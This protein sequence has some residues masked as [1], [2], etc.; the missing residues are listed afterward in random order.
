MAHTPSAR[1]RFTTRAVALACSQILAPAADAQWTCI[2]LHP[3]GTVFSSGYGVGD[4]QQVG[5]VQV[6][7]TVGHQRAAVWSGTAGSWINLHPTTMGYSVAFAASGG[8]QAGGYYPA[9]F[10]RAALWSGSAATYVDLH[11]SAA[12]SQSGVTG[13]RAGQ[14]VGWTIQSVTHA[15]LWHGTPGSWV[16]LNPPPTA[17][18]EHTSE[19]Y[20]TDGTQQVG[21]VVNVGGVISAALWSGSAAW[22]N[23]H[24]TSMISSWAYGVA[25]GQQAG[26]VRV[27]ADGGASHAALWT[28]SAASWVDLHPAGYLN[29]QAWAVAKGMQVGRIVSSGVAHAALWKGTAASLVDLHAFTPS[30]FVSSE[31][32]AIWTDATGTYIVGSGYSNLTGREEALLW[33]GPAPCVAPNVTTHPLAQTSCGYSTIN[34]SVAA[35]GS[36]PFTYQWRNGLVPINPLTNPSA[37]TDTLVLTAPRSADAG[38][39]D[40]VVTNACGNGTSNPAVLRVCAADINCDGLIDILDFLDYIDAFSTCEGLPAPCS[41]TIGVDADYNADTI[42]DILDLLDFLNDLGTGC[43]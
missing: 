3:S 10:S 7:P 28:G 14:Q 38:S 18:Y 30:G 17:G 9:G 8:Q 13:V 6:G 29:S 41:S 27:L 1:R 23:L 40:C 43:V 32:R 11:P 19:A 21:Y 4:G 33:T 12:L 20:G 34:F 42:V 37:A 15:A 36:G 35:S 22:V 39:Y 25:D 31:A 5:Y 24:P 16:D 2:S 26:V